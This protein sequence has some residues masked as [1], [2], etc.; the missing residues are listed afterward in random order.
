MCECV[1]VCAWCLP[2]RYSSVDPSV[3]VCWCI[4]FRVPRGHSREH[5]RTQIVANKHEYGPCTHTHAHSTYPSTCLYISCINIRHT[6][7]PLPRHAHTINLS[8]TTIRLMHCMYRLVCTHI[9]THT[10]THTHTHSHI[11]SVARVRTS[12]QLCMYRRDG[13]AHPG[14]QRARARNAYGS[15]GVNDDEDGSRQHRGFQKTA[16][17]KARAANTMTRPTTSSRVRAGCIRQRSLP[18]VML[19]LAYI[20]M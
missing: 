12:Y 9:H 2:V 5:K 15:A 13:G 20:V 1:C 7:K 4:A 10:H 19:A 8:L 3:A 11:P 16:T 18:V 17:A 14:R 6:R